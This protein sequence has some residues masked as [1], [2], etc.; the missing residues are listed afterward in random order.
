MIEH[1]FVLKATRGRAEGVFPAAYTGVSIDSRDLPRGGLFFAVRGERD[2]HDYVRTAFE[3]GAS[4]AVV[5]NRSKGLFQGARPGENLIFVP[6]TARA[7]ADM[8][9]AWRKNF[10]DLK[11]VCITG[12]SGKTTT[13]QAL[14]CILKSAGRRAV[15]SRKSFN[16]HLGLPLTLLEM[17]EGCEVC[18]AEVGI[19]RPG[20]MDGLARIAVP[21]MGAV[22][23]IGTAHIGGFGSRERI[24]E[25]KARLFRFFSEENHLAVNLDDPLVSKISSDVSCM[26]TGF[27]INSPGAEVSASAVKG[28]ERSV[29]FTMK[30]KGRNFPVTAP[31]AG[32]HNVMN[33]LCAASLALALGLSG[34][35]IARGIER[36]EPAEMRMQV[37]RIACGAA[38]IND[39]Y[40]SNPDSLNAALEEL[41]QMKKSGQKGAKA[42]AV[43]GD[44]LE[45]GEFSRKYHRMAGEKASLCGVDVLIGFG[46]MAEDMRAGAGSKVYFEKTLSHAEAADII[47]AMAKPGDF[48]LIKGSRAMAMEKIVR[49]IS[50]S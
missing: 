33:F 30:I 14:S 8:A 27:G 7:L 37:S 15:A 10:K 17:R 31:T 45:L 18:V 12:S 23:N 25:E 20:E 47:K 16:N 3:A 46:E 13:K 24:S 26:K 22:T 49:R 9:L 5:E 36:F 39:F 29:S 42:I 6:S 1:D 21:D 35:E 2:G 32:A 43:L 40:N 4:A 48:I 50:G 19:N 38:L 44:M 28:S 11:V 34:D 41:F